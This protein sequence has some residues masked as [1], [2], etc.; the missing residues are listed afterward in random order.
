MEKGWI[1]RAIA[2]GLECGLSVPQAYDQVF[3]PP[4]PAQRDWLVLHRTSPHCSEDLSVFVSRAP[5]RVRAWMLRKATLADGTRPGA[6]VVGADSVRRAVADLTGALSE[7]R[8]D[9][10]RSRLR[11]AEILETM[12]FRDL[13]G[14]PWR[15]A[16]KST[17][18]S[19]PTAHRRYQ[20]HCAEFI[21]GGAYAAL[22]VQA[23]QRSAR[24]FVSR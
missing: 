3:G 19:V 2:P 6:P 23:V 7:T 18:V 14:M 12:L 21:L 16:A 5:E 15:E 20:L 8:I 11:A 10:R 17:G 9:T 13:C 1:H 24:E 4:T 22:A